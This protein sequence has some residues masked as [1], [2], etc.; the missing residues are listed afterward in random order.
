MY[1]VLQQ[2]SRCESSASDVKG[3]KRLQSLPI[4]TP[5][6]HSI[7]CTGLLLKDVFSIDSAAAQVYSEGRMSRR[8]DALALGD[9]MW[10]KGPKG[11]F[12]YTPNMKQ[13]IGTT[14]LCLA[15][16]LLLAKRDDGG[17]ALACGMTWESRSK[18]ACL[19]AVRCA[20]GKWWGLSVGVSF[21]TGSKP[22]QFCV[23]PLMTWPASPSLVGACSTDDYCVVRYASGRDGHHANVPGRSG[24]FEEPCG[25]HRSMP[26]RMYVW[27]GLFVKRM[28][29]HAWPAGQFA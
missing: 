5:T 9:T 3:S 8:M 17:K 23:R 11:R 19:P 21:S 15:L 4:S 6:N 12:N 27:T 25:S 22:S 20:P 24:N 10:F 18:H 1:A 2:R 29:M 16:Y 7:I 13:H 14:M 28:L 26:C